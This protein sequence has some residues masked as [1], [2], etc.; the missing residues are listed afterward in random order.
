MGPVNPIIF[1]KIG[2]KAG[3]LN[4]LSITGFENRGN[5]SSSATTNILCVLQ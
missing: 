3:I 4:L 1:I 5:S 2:K